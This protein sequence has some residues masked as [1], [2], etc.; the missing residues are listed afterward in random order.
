MRY[1]TELKTTTAQDQKISFWS[2]KQFIL[3]IWRLSTS[4]HPIFYFVKFPYHVALWRQNIQ[5]NQEIPETK[6]DHFN[7]RLFDNVF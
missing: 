1:E 6:P 5:L 7:F 3:I 2:T 4:L